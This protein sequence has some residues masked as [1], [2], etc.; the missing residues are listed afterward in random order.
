MPLLPVQ[1]R[2]NA[3]E[4]DIG[5][6]PIV[7]SLPPNEHSK[8]IEQELQE[9]EAGNSNDE[10]KAAGLTLSKTPSRKEIVPSKARLVALVLTLTGA[11]F[12]NV[13][14]SKSKLSV[15]ARLRRLLA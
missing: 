15:E 8:T 10:E 9:V 14:L 1:R 7:N 2:Q 5:L 4:S 6:E 11:S 13:S 3:R 12:L